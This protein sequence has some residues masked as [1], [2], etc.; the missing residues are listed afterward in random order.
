[1]TTSSPR[2]SA[3]IYQFPARARRTAGRCAQ[4]SARDAAA[5][6]PSSSAACHDSWYHQAAIQDADRA[7]LDGQ[8]GLRQ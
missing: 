5:L 1:M 3:R 4:D 2:E 6:A 8:G 7:R